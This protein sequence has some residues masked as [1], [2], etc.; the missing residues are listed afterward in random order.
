MVG[1]TDTSG[2]I[3]ESVSIDVPTRPIRRSQR[4]HRQIDFG[5]YVTS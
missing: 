5:P 4:S 1:N 3:S 2:N